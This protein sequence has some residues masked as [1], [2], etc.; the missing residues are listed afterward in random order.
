MGAIQDKFKGEL[1]VRIQ[2]AIAAAE[3]ERAKYDRAVSNVNELKD[4]IM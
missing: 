3:T 2:P 1:D 4:Q